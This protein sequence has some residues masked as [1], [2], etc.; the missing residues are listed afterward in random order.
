MGF[1]YRS[2]CLEINVLTASKQQFATLRRNL[3]DVVRLVADRSRL[4]F[5]FQITDWVV[6]RSRDLWTWRGL[7][8]AKA[9]TRGGET[10][11]LRPHAAFY[12]LK[13]GPT[14]DSKFYTTN[15]FTSTNIVVFVFYIFFSYFFFF[16]VILFLNERI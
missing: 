16:F 11:D 3:A 12:I 5:K 8:N 14:P 1:K 6:V 9:Y 2:Q 7:M 13:W 4:R 15:R 10:S